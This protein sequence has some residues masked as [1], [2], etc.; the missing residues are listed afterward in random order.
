VD[1]SQAGHAAELARRA[2]ARE[3]RVLHLNLHET[4]NGR[5][6]PIETDADASYMVEAA[7][8]ELRMAGNVATAR[9]VQSAGIRTRDADQKIAD[10]AAWGADLIVLG[11]PRRS[12]FASRLFGSVTLRVLKAAHCPV[13]VAWWKDSVHATPVAAEQYAGARS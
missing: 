7:V 10:A 11:A 12:G 2:G 1:A 3:A 5:R 6:F 13:M 4:I 8:F 9:S